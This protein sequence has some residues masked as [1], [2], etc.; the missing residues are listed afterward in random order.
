GFGVAPAPMPRFVD[1]PMRVVARVA[2]LEPE[3]T[4][5][6][7]QP[8]ER[9]SRLERCFRRRFAGGAD[10][11]RV[12]AVMLAVTGRGVDLQYVLHTQPAAAFAREDAQLIVVAAVAGD[13][14]QRDAIGGGLLAHP[15]P[16]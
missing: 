14:I 6:R 16:A 11:Q 8:R 10:I 4:G 2:Q 12:A 15:L 9:G 5:M 7:A 13:R 1:N 3:A